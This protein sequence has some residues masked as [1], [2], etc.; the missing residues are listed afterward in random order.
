[1]AEP[2]PVSFERSTA[3]GEAP[4]ESLARAALGTGALVGLVV[5]VI[6][7]GAATYVAVATLV[8]EQPGRAIVNARAILAVEEHLGVAFERDAQRSFL[9][10][11]VAGA[12]SSAVY[13]LVYWPF[14]V[15]TLLI[16][17]WRDRSGFR[18]MRNA[19]LISGAVG[20]VAIALFPVSP[21]RM[22]EGYEDRLADM[23]V[24]GS[25][26]HPDGLFNPH[27]AMPSF[28]VGWMVVAAFGLRGLAG[29]VW[30]WTPPALMAIAVVTTGNHYVLDVVAGG[31]LALVAWGLAAPMQRRLDEAGLHRAGGR[32]LESPRG[33]RPGM[34]RT[35]RAD[36]SAE[37][38]AE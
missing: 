26:A 29:P 18:L 10:Q 2:L 13:A 33:C 24:L 19:L 28:H 34:L 5:L 37:V 22:L 27:A 8:D 31:G 21:P 30:R 20:L 17:A 1:M 38:V 16:T 9:G 23:P 32:S 14:V 11:G 35:R 6:V 15:G 12:I 25:L 36:G 3:A 4:P 7:V